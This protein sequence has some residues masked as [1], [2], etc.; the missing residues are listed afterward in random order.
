MALLSELGLLISLLKLLMNKDNGGPSKS[1]GGGMT[2]RKGKEGEEVVVESKPRMVARP[3][4]AR[5]LL[6]SSPKGAQVRRISQHHLESNIIAGKRGQF[7]DVGWAVFVKPPAPCLPLS[8]NVN[9]LPSKDGIFGQVVQNK[10]YDVNVNNIAC[11]LMA[12]DQII[13]DLEL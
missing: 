5:A 1:D 6:H 2:K 13:R 7:H 4:Y 12:I 8:S 11:E 10:D 3:T 9:P